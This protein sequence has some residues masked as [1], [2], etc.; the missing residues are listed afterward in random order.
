MSSV[1]KG[2]IVL[3]I[4][5]IALVLLGASCDSRDSGSDIPGPITQIG[6]LAWVAIEPRQ[7]MT[8]PWEVDWLLQ[9]GDSESYPKDPRQPGLEPGEVLIIQDYY[10]RQGV[11]VSDT[12]TAPRYE[13][14]CMAC[15]CPEGHTMYLRVREGDVETMTG[16]G[17]RVESPA[18]ED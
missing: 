8:N 12:A 11:I 5:S 18:D 2:S 6:Q 14:V 4:P 3:A 10:S 9:H 13:V 15:T 16:F 1:L 7:C 17:Y